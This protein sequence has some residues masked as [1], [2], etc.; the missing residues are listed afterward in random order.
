MTEIRG[1]RNAILSYRKT[2][3][4]YTQYRESDWSP[5]FY[6]E[7]KAEI[8]AHK[9]AQAVYGAADGKLPTLSELSEEFD[10][11]L[12]QKR[13]DSEA[14]SQQNVELSREKFPENF[15]FF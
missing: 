14:L 8:E 4:I 15:G 2:K 6:R 11:L 10:R 13:V 1:P 5:A 3:Y 12:N 9:K 7:H